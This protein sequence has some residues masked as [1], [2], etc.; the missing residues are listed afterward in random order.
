[1]STKAS[2]QSKESSAY[3]AL[4]ASSS[5]QAVLDAIGEEGRHRMWFANLTDDVAGDPNY[6]STIHTD[7]AGTKSIIGYLMW[8]ETGELRW[9]TGLAVDSLVMNLDDVA[10]V[11]ALE[12]LTFANAIERNSKRIPEEAVG[13]IVQGYREHVALLRSLDLPIAMGGGETA[14]LNDIVQTLVVGST[15]FGRVA[16]RHALSFER[17]SPGDVIVGLASTGQATFEARPNSGIGSNGLT[18]ARHA[19]LHRDYASQ[20]PE[21]LDD[22]LDSGVLYRGPFRLTEMCEPLGMSIGEALLSPTR[23]YAPIVARCMR[24]VGDLIH[25]IVH[26]TGG[27]QTKIQ[28]FGRGVRYVKDNLFP[29]PPLFN[30]IQQHGR[31]EWSEMY[32]VFN[33]GHRMELVCA[34]EAVETI[35]QQAAKFGVSAQVVGRVEAGDRARNELVIDSP[36]GTFTY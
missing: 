27:G 7:D 13:A 6:L 32:A 21:A 10:C 31:I 14:D 33:M 19:L 18:L 8:R 17:V 25:G 3:Q 26:C 30:L 11:N 29:T 4:G 15:L 20:Y 2:P 16:R 5:K 24:A 1:M 23:T 28:R 34:R 35:M 36:Y 9:F 12:S 22:Q